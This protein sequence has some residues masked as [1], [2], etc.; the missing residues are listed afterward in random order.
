MLFY[1]IVILN[2]KTIE[3]SEFVSASFLSFSTVVIL[4]CVCAAVKEVSYL[5][6]TLIIFIQNDTKLNLR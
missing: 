2:N 5:Q 6:I 4:M 1:E 3:S